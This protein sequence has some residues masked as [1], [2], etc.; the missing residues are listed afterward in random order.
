M[1]ACVQANKHT[2]L[3]TTLPQPLFPSVGGP[4]LSLTHLPFH[5]I[6]AQCRTGIQKTTQMGA[7]LLSGIRV[8]FPAVRRVGY[9]DG[10]ILGH[11][12]ASFGT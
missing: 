10:T 11:L 2:Y 5:T 6:H 9:P 3:R 7:M 1:H 4:Y 8:G 12:T